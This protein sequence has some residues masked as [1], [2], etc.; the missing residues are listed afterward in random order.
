MTKQTS[1]IYTAE[2]KEI[3][4]RE[5]HGWNTLIVSVKENGKEIGTYKRNYPSLMDTFFP[6]CQDGEWYALYSPKYTSTR[7]MKLP[8]CKDIGGEEDIENGFCPTEYFVPFGKRYESIC[9]VDKEGNKI[10][11]LKEKLSGK[12]GFVAGCHW[13]D[14]SSDK[15]QFLD[16]SDVK[17]GNIKRDD[18]FGYI[19]LPRSENIKLKDF[20][21][22]DC[23]DEDE[24][25]PY[26]EIATFRRFH[27]W[28]QT[29]KP[30]NGFCFLEM[31][32]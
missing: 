14:D 11:I 27:L 2:V 18:R 15:V 22:L 7:I 9:H 23:Y 19:E 30:V 32:K 25:Y 8:E 17:N 3:V 16:L 28:D 13:G 21:N 26:V 29:Q 12:S 4:K 31:E 24:D 1:P 10:N 6:F 20:I 5:P